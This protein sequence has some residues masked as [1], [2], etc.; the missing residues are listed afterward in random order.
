[1]S[2]DAVFILRNYQVTEETLPIKI[3]TAFNNTID[4]HR[5]KGLVFL[6]WFQLY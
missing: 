2:I 6:K 5:D 1:M 4:L 3:I